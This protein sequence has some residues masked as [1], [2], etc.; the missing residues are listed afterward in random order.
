M[1]KTRFDYLVNNACACGCLVD[2]SIVMITNNPE[3]MATKTFHFEGFAVTYQEGHFLALQDLKT[4]KYICE[5]ECTT[6]E[7]Q[8]MRDQDLQELIAEAQKELK[9]RELKRVKTVKKVLGETR[10][11]LRGYG[12]VR[13]CIE[14]DGRAPF[15]TTIGQLRLKALPPT[16]EGQE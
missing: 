8:E 15:N 3:C 9:A 1:T 5:N 6:V 2:T 7:V 14:A 12:D 11:Q 10:K 16:E 4:G 13:L